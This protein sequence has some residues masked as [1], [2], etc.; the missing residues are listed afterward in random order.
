[1]GGLAGTARHRQRAAGKRIEGAETP[2]ALHVKPQGLALSDQRPSR[3]AMVSCQTRQG[4]GRAVHRCQV[5]RRG[6][7][8]ESITKNRQPPEVLLA[9]VE[10]AYGRDRTPE[11]DEGVSELGH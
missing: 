11:G 6:A 4:A 5:S 1:M 7:G 2:M 9:M 3:K 8:V 10:R